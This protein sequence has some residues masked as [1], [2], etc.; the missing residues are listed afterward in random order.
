M[1]CASSNPLTMWSNCGLY[2]SLP[3]G[4]PRQLPANLPDGAISARAGLVTSPLNWQQ[5]Y[6]FDDYEDYEDYDEDY[7]DYYD[8]YYYSGDY[9]D[10]SEGAGSE[11]GLLGLLGGLLGG[12]QEADHTQAGDRLDTGQ[13]AEEGEGLGRLLAGVGFFTLLLPSVL[14]GAVLFVLSAYRYRTPCC[15]GL[16][17]LG[18]P[19]AQSMF[20]GASLVT[21]YLLAPHSKALAGIL[22]PVTLDAAARWALIRVLQ[23]LQVDR[24]PSLHYSTVV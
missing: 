13:T 15:A 4:Y 2:T 14:A 7:A 12:D 8:D 19:A 11:T 5:Y 1:V 22:S 6:D 3:Y 23:L 10:E 20:A 17:Y 16:L 21:T 24:T 18:V 9:P